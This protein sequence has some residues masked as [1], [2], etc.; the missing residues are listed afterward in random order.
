MEY[1]DEMFDQF[2]QAFLGEME[3]EGDVPYRNK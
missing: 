3:G 1:L 2:S